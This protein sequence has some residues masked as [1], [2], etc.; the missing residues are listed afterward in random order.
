MKNKTPSRI[1]LPRTNFHTFSIYI[2]LFPYFLHPFTGYVE[3]G[4][5]AWVVISVPFTVSAPLLSSRG[6]NLLKDMTR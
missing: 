5:T 4:K 3:A 2:F 1:T 6:R